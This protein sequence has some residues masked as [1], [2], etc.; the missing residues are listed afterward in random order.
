LSLTFRLIV[1][2]AVD[3]SSPR[4]SAS[5]AAPLYWDT[6]ETVR[7]RGLCSNAQTFGA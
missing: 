4:V 3:M 6:I 2:F 1:P 7:A 5:D